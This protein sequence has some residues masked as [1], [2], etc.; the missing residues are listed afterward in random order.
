[1][2][3]HE[4]PRTQEG[5]R[6]SP[7]QGRPARRTAAIALGV[8]GTVAAFVG[9]FILLGGDSS[10]VQFGWAD[11]VPATDVDAGWG[12]GLLIV[13][14]ISLAAAAILAVRDRRS[15]ATADVNALVEPP[16]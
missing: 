13:A 8:G 14:T 16:R 2:S 6:G 3:V 12:Y 11:P 9:A 15:R 5:I 4:H 10:Y 1:M 7:E